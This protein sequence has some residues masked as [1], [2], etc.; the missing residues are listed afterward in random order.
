MRKKM[1]ID[2]Y[3]CLPTERQLRGIMFLPTVSKSAISI[4]YLTANLSEVVR[5]GRMNSLS[6][7][8]V[9]GRIS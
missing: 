2:G 8:Q 7:A 1:E 5:E 4:T 9:S 6:D 3:V